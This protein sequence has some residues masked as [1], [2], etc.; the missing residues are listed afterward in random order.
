MLSVKGTNELEANET[1]SNADEACFWE[2]LYSVD[3]FMIVEDFIIWQ[4]NT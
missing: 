1:V 4:K 3:C 2:S